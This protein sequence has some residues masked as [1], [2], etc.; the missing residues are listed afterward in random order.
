MGAPFSLARRPCAFIQ[1]GMQALL[2]R[3]ALG[4]AEGA[5]LV[6]RPLEPPGTAAACGAI[7]ELLAH[8]D[9]TAIDVHLACGWSRLLLLPWMDQLSSEQRWENYAQARFEQVFGED[10]LAWEIHMARNVPGQDRIAVAWPMALRAAF[11]E[12]ANVRSVRVGL[13]EHM[14]VLLAHE[15]DFSGC[16]IEIEAD[17]AGFVLLL[18]GRPR[19]V[20]W[21]RFDDDEG[22]SAAVRS[23][24][25]SVLAAEALAPGGAVG[26]ALTPPIPERDSARAATVA[27]LAIGLGFSRAFSLPE[28]P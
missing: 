10:A 17:G 15:P 5:G 21:S 23:E 16:L 8:Y 6:A 3:P 19:R 4:V 9:K 13:L 20:R 11:A 28:W 7:R 27:A 24:W 22:L 1:L 12:H 25:A 26:L 14:G 18:N 2:L